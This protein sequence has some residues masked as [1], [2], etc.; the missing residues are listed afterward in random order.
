MDSAERV[1]KRYVR[2][3]EGQTLDI[4]ALLRALAERPKVLVRFFKPAIV[5]LLP[6]AKFKPVGKR[7]AKTTN[8]SKSKRV[9]L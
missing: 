2:L 9:R 1:L 7:K 6:Q 4:A 3:P 5:K 8:G